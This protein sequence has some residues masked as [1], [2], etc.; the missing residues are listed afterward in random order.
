[1]SE[2]DIIKNIP[3]LYDK[4]DTMEELYANYY[5]PLLK[6]HK[7]EKNKTI[8]GLSQDDAVKVLCGLNIERITDIK[9]TMDNLKT[10]ED[11]IF[12]EI[13]DNMDKN[14]SVMNKNINN[15]NSL[16]CNENVTNGFRKSE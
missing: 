15:L 14:I 1:M 16:K 2:E 6:E 8:C 10:Y 3:D 5:L 12:K 13:K 4:C 11:M 9:M 7:K